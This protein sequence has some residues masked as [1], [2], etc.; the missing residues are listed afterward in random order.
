MQKVPDSMDPK[1][2]AYFKEMVTRK[3][4]ELDNLQNPGFKIVSEKR[5]ESIAQIYKLLLQLDQSQQ[6]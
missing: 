6:H 5:K 3:L 4:L 2:R 1:S